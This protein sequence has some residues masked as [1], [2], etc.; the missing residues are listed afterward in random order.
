M[1]KLDQKKELLKK[2]QKKKNKLDKNMES[3]KKVLIL[4]NNNIKDL[5]S[6]IYNEQQIVDEKNT[7]IK[8]NKYAN[9]L[10]I[11]D[12]D[13]LNFFAINHKD[14]LT[15]AYANNH[16]EGF[17]LKHSDCGDECKWDGYSKRCICGNV[18]VYWDTPVIDDWDTPVIDDC[19]TIT[20]MYPA[21]Y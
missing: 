10:K 9:H 6:D 11:Y 18:T 16:P 20:E 2:M 7:N 15:K 12:D 21:Y 19:F 1:T 8:I 14:I 13:D 3:L 5:N 4:T 17:K